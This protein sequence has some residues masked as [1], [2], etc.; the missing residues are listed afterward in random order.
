[1][2][3]LSPPP[4]AGSGG[5]AP[6]IVAPTTD[7]PT[8]VP[9]T[10]S[11]SLSQRSLDSFKRSPIKFGY[12]FKQSSGK[13][14]RRRWNQRW[15]VLDY[16]TGI[17][18]YFRHASLPEAVPFRQDAH[19]VIL[20]KEP[21]VSLVILGDLPRG[22]P[23]PFC[24]TVS[25][26]SN[27]SFLI[28]ADTNVDF[29][30]WTSAISAILSPR[31]AV[32][33]IEPIPTSQDSTRVTVKAASPSSPRPRPPPLVIPE[34]SVAVVEA[35]APV[36]APTKAP[37][38]RSFSVDQG[39]THKQVVIVFLVLN[40]FIAI[41]R[42]G[43]RELVVL[44]MLGFNIV[45]VWFLWFAQPVAT[46]PLVL[47]RVTREQSSS[48]SSGSSSSDDSPA[49]S[50]TNLLLAVTTAPF[51]RDSPKHSLMRIEKQPSATSTPRPS[52][53]QGLVN[54]TRVKAGASIQMCAPAPA[55]IVVGCW[56]HISGTRYQVRQGPNYRKT[57]IKAP[58]DESLLDLVAIDIY[59]SS[60]KVDNIASLVDLSGLLRMG[61]SSPLDLFVV[62]C[63]V[64]SYQPSNPL[65][66]EKQ[67]DGEGFNF[68]TYFAIPPNVREQ[69]NEAE[70]THQAVRLLKNFLHDSSTVRDRFKAI[71]IVVNPEEQ[72]LGRTE[73]HLLETYNGQ[74]ILTRPQHRFYRTESYFEVDVDAHEF[75]YVARRGLV[76]VSEHFKNMVV[77][78]GF[79]LEGQ[80]DHELP[81][82]ILGGVRLCKIDVSKA[83][84][85]S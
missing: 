5:T 17:L 37:L 33:T 6:A 13:W 35:K 14:H 73:R 65:W 21:G 51:R 52:R 55:A 63:Q 39:L 3:Q 19:G 8:R 75:N 40:P 50:A 46:M 7:A 57:K 31:K 9:L 78:F 69:L 30:E 81:E 23:T 29:R 1:M 60:R 26:S 2:I 68:V 34:P 53:I 66:G 11:S 16:D 82:Q 41:V 45:V 56:T 4:S 32:E 44:A 25:D 43:S 83:Q 74:P 49:T 80:D 76:G 85:M 42:Y 15:F 12:L 24:F 71:G 54:G 67:G 22:V 48:S 58:S 20:L 28:C 64:P 59:R 18:K 10:S 27:R 61:A 84:E 72:K 36:A 79:V 70:P 77:D 47:Q 62:N 38:R